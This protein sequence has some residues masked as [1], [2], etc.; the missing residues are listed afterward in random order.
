MP[1]FA[2]VLGLGA[3]GCA[4]EKVN[5]GH[6]LTTF[7]LTFKIVND[8]T[9]ADWFKQLS[10]AGLDSLSRLNP[11]RGQQPVGTPVLW[12]I[13]L[14][15]GAYYLPATGGELTHTLLLHLSPTD[16][17]TVEAKAQFGPLVNTDCNAYHELKGLELRYNGR[18]N[19]RYGFGGSWNGANFSCSGCGSVEVVRKRP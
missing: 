9:G 5:C 6:G 10:Q 4:K 11:P 8:R 18:L 12:G 15:D 14:S 16:T 13:S 17:D 19:G 2:F 7:Y 1:F 3:S